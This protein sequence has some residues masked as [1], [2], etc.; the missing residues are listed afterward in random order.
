MSAALRI[1]AKKQRRDYRAYAN[2]H[3]FEEFTNWVTQR[4]LAAD[5]REEQGADDYGAPKQGGNR[6]ARWK[7]R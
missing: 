5:R 2:I 6:F 1:S 7:V 3:L 4:A